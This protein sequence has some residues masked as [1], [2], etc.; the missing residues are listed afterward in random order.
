MQSIRATQVPFFAGNGT[1]IFKTTNAG[2]SWADVASGSARMP[3]QAVAVNSGTVI[4]FS[5]VNA[6]SARTTN[7]GSTWVNGGLDCNTDFIAIMTG[8]KTTS[9]SV[10]FAVGYHQGSGGNTTASL[11]RSTNGGSSPW[12]EIRSGSSTS[13]KFN[14]FLVDPLNTERVYVFGKKEA[15]DNISVSNDGGTQFERV[16]IPDNNSSSDPEIS[17]MAV[18]ATGA[19]SQSQKIY[20]AVYS[21]S[22]SSQKGVWKSTDAGVH[23]N[24][25][26]GDPL[27]YNSNGTGK[28]V[29]VLSMA[30]YAPGRLFAAGDSSGT[31]WLR[32]SE[33]GGSTWKTV[34]SMT[35]QVTKILQHPSYPIYMYV[36]A[37][38]GG[39]TKVYKSTNAGY[40][41]WTDITG[42]L[43]TPIYDLRSSPNAGYLYAATANGIY[44]LNIE[45]A[46]P[47][48]VGWQPK[49]EGSDKPRIFW[50]ANQENGFSPS[51]W[52]QVHR[53]LESCHYIG[54]NKIT[55]TPLESDQVIGSTTNTYL[56]DENFGVYAEPETYFTRAYYYVLAIDEG[57]L[58]SGPS[59]TIGLDGAAYDA[60]K[61]IF[62][63]LPEEQ[64]PKSFA[65]NANYPNPF[66]PST[67]IQ[68]Q[69]PVDNVVTIKV[70]DIL[71]REVATLVNEFQPAGYKSVD[72]DASSFTS[73]MYYYRI[74][75]GTF[76]EIKKM[77]LMK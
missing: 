25:L 49:E 37:G 9:G 6:V 20:A 68:Y 19:E 34:T 1:T 31:Y 51:G 70:F 45:P 10:V 15:N 29:R 35:T 63:P 22:T 17:D 67:T 39:N 57:N 16:C 54:I 72:F 55:C 77:V 41:S 47:A 59:S 76:S 28:S 7:A 8:F 13:G 26:T 11:W 36:I 62:N 33:D 38:T 4:T 53:S 52:Y 60:N 14:G 12:T 43:P 44:K 58:Y 69:L 61:T 18:D 2:S 30:P 32:L 3:V 56:D 23:W 48:S 21:S 75:A 24:Q 50:S 65:L 66:N 5:S 64:K 27:I 71:G 74:Q 46:A 40:S 42:S 73:G